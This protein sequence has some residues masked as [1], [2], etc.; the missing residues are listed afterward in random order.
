M[1]Q[2]RN[3]KTT[4]EQLDGRRKNRGRQRRNHRT[5]MAERT[6][7]K[8]IG[9]I[10]RLSKTNSGN[11]LQTNGKPTAKLMANQRQTNGK[12]KRQ[13]KRQTNGKPTAKPTAK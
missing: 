12:T 6:G 10:K 1:E 11:Q 3:H 8:I 13:T 2:R 7:N 9:N 4:T 5:A